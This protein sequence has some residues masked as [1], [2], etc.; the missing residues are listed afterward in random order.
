MSERTRAGADLGPLPP[1][2][3]GAESCSAEF[4]ADELLLRAG[5]PAAR[6]TVLADRAVSAGVGVRPG[7]AFLE[8]AAADGLPVVRRTS[9]G[10]GVLHEPGDLAWSLVL[11]RAHAAVGAGF[12]RGYARLGAGVVRFLGRRGLA[13][14]WTPPPNLSPDCCVLSGRGEV[15]S[16]DARIVG[17][18]AQHLSAVALLHQGM[19]SSTVDRPRVARLFGIADPSAVA[20]LVGLD[21]LGVR[22]PPERL[23]RE[24]ADAL[25]A[26][27][28]PN[29]R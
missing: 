28:S 15:L 9:G 5:R 3:V 26:G 14:S 22:D 6:V 8:R 12:V 1:V 13:A 17:G 27:F 21:D 16:V 4:R 10:S 18:A 2:E 7:A 25:E 23:A 19:V 20:R 29:A 24:L 11:P